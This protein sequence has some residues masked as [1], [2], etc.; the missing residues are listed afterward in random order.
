MEKVVVT[1]YTVGL[2][3]MEFCVDQLVVPAKSTEILAGYGKDHQKL[4]FPAEELGSF[5]HFHAGKLNREGHSN[6]FFI[7]RGG[8]IFVINVTIR[9]GHCDVY[10][11]ELS[12]SSRVWLPK[13]DHRIVVPK[14]N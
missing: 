2:S 3:G 4:F 12:S 10:E 13:Y 14:I 6:L 11:E 5:V 9:G 8:K 7:E 1:L